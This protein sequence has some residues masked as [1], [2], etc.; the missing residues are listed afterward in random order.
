MRWPK[1]VASGVLLLLSIGGFAYAAFYNPLSSFSSRGNDHAYNAYGEVP[2]PGDQTLHL[3]AGQVAISLHAETVGVPEVGLP[4]PQLKLDI[5]PP[6]GVA[7]PQVDEKYGGTTTFNNDSHRQVWLAQIPQT[8]DYRITTDGQVTAFVS[9]RLAFGQVEKSAI[10]SFTPVWIRPAATVL[11]SVAFI[12]AIALF[13]SA[14]TPKLRE[15]NPLSPPEA[16]QPFPAPV[17]PSAP[18]PGAARIERLKTL[19][20]LHASGA[21]TDDEFE[22]EKRR[23]I[24]E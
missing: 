3:P 2:I 13:R 20:D 24:G 6:D 17:Q 4:I 18:D 9:A 11:A 23:T 21:L 8:G 19:A 12:A 15:Y 14:S 16:E 1:L 22:A 10:P 7:D 5:V